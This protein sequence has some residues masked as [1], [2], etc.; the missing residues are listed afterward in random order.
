MLVGNFQFPVPVSV[1]HC[2]RESF[3]SKEIISYISQR[4]GKDF[5]KFFEQYLYH[6]SIPTVEYRARKHGKNKITVEFRML[7]EVKDFSMSYAFLNGKNKMT[8]EAGPE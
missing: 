8:V 7:S 6:A 4:S 5:T 3:H 2:I 1:R